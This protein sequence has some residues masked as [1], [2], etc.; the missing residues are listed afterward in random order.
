M[1]ATQAPSEERGLRARPP[2]FVTRHGTYVALY[3]S[4]GRQVERLSVSLVPGLQALEGDQFTGDGA[5][6]HRGWAG[7]PNLT[8]AAA[9]RKVP[10]EGADGHLPGAG[11]G[12]W[13]AIGA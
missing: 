9:P 10:V 7:E 11:G 4:P 1:G 8:W 13:A 3:V 5:R 6:C 12:S 2:P